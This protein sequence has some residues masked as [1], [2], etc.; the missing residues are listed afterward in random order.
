MLAHIVAAL[1]ALD[2]GHGL[3]CKGGTALRLCYFEDYRYSADLD[4]S[5]VEGGIEAAYATI[6]AALGTVVG[7]VDALN[8]TDHEPKRIAYRGPL[9]RHRHLKL[10]I[11]DRE[12]VLDMNTVRL[13]PRW[14][15]LPDTD[16][17]RV[18]PLAEIAGKKLRCVMQR[19]QCRDLFDLWLLFETG[20]VD[21]RDAAKVFR[22]K[23]KHRQLDPDRFKV[24]YRARLPQYR[25]RWTT[26][27]AI[28]VPGEVPHF[29]HVE[30]TVSRRLR[31]VGLL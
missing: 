25:D 17:V 8:L 2:G 18:Y 12:I 16:A 1:G 6:E 14:P 3:V 21:S 27:L 5:V 24:Y 26:E 20:T 11:T 31:A 9:G 15:D 7:A 22:P 10:D 30:R 29:E 23:A 19:M 4:F 28:H 13:L